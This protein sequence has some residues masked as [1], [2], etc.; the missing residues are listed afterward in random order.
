MAAERIG[1]FGVA[2]KGFNTD[3]SGEKPAGDVLAGVA[4]G[5]GND[6]KFR[7]VGRLVSH[8][9]AEFRNLLAEFLVYVEIEEGREEGGLTSSQSIVLVG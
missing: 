6:V 9:G 4:E 5:A 3:T 8:D 2:G 7:F 1:T